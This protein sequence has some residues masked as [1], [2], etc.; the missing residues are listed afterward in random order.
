MIGHAGILP[1]LVFGVVML[2][3][4]AFVIVFLAHRKPPAAPESK[5]EGSF[6]GIALQAAAYLI[7]WMVRRPFL[8]PIVS[9]RKPL[10]IALAVFA[11]FLAVISI[12]FTA[13]AVRT[14]GTHWSIAARLVEGHR[15]ITEGPYRWVRH[16]IYT[17]ML[18][19]L[20]AT[21][22]AVSRWIALPFALIVYAIGTWLRVRSE[23]K[24]LREAFGTQFEEYAG[25]VPA[26]IPF[27]F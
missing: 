20:L 6:A 22:L 5:R 3:W 10:D 24:L 11:M 23:E 8:S 1:A 26:V 27:L 18:G 25:K 16:P 13:K 15:L 9:S 21:G 2:C 17:G 19:M 12:W 4:F 7:I 14:L